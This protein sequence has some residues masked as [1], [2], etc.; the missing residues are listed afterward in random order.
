MNN[1]DRTDSPTPSHGAAT[2]TPQE[3]RDQVK[4]TRDELGQTVEALAGKTDIKARA[5]EKTDSV[6]S[7]AVQK[8]ALVSDQIREKAGQAAQMAKDK[9][10]DPLREKTAQTAAQVRESATAA[11]QYAT[12]KTPDL[13][14][15]KAGQAVTAARVNRIPLLVFGAAAVVFLLVRR[16]RGHRR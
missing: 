12:E 2:P 11:V 9:T 1:E 3:L 14:V 6:K 13:L 4:H 15:D 5:K 7:Q 10:P 8:A 16:G